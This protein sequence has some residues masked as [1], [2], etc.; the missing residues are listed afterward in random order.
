MKSTLVNFHSEQWLLRYIATQCTG[1]SK[2]FII[3]DN[4]RLD[5]L[6]PDID[7]QIHPMLEYTQCGNN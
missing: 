6:V 3:L 1:S 2:G 4:D 7:R 5:T